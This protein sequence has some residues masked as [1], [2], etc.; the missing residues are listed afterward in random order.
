MR[1]ALHRPRHPTLIPGPHPGPPPGPGRRAAGLIL[2]LAVAL[3]AGCEGT[4]SDESVDL[5]AAPPVDARRPDARPTT[6]DAAPA[7][8]DDF[9][10]ACTAS[11]DCRSGF[12]VAG[13]GEA[14][15]CSRRC[16]DDADCPA[17]WLCR[18][19][20][21]AEADVTFIC[22]PRE[23][24]CGGADLAT[25]LAHC[26]ACDHPC[27]ALPGADPACIGGACAAGPCREGFRDLD[28]D[29]ANGCEY[30]CLLTRGG[31][32]A[33]D[34]IDNDCDGTS[35]EGFDLER[36]AAHCGACNA[37]C[38]P[39]NA[40]GACVV[41]ACEVADCA[42][43]FADE[44]GRADNGCEAARC[45]PNDTPE[46]CNGFD[47]DCDGA[48]DEGIDLAADPDHCGACDTPCRPADARGDCVSG[49]CT[50]G[51]C[52]D[53]FLDLDGAPEDGCEYACAG[54]APDDL[55]C[56]GRD[57]DCDG[58]I[59]EDVDLDA[60]PAH[61]GAC[62]VRCERPGAITTCA[63]GRCARVACEDGRLDLDGDPDNG[64]EV[65]CVPAPEQCNGRDDDCDGRVDEDFDLTTDAARC[66]ACD[67]ACAFPGAAA[68]C[69]D[70][71]CALGACLAGLADQNG[72]PADG[73]EYACVPTLGG[74]EA[75][76]AIDNDCDGDTDEDTDLAA[77][78]DHCGACNHACRLPNATPACVNGAC[79]IGA[80]LGDFQ[81]IDGR[82]ED[83]CESG[84]VPSNGGVEICDGLDNDCDDAADEGF[85][86]DADL[87]H[88][89]ACGRAC[90]PPGAE[91]VC[92]AGLCA[93]AACDAGFVDLNGD[94]RDGCEYA[95]AP[96]GDETCDGEDEDC[97]GRADEGFDLQ[98]DPSHCG[99]CDH[100]CAF[101]QGVPAC[102]GGACVLAGCAEGFVDRDGDTANGCECRVRD[103]G[104]ETCDGVDQ[105][106]DGR[107]DEGFDLQGDARHC[108]AC[109]HV[110]AA[111]NAVA[112]CRDG[113][114]AVGDCAAGFA[115]LDGDAANGCECGLQAGG[116]EAC[117]GADQ[118]C[119]GR[120]DEGFDL[121]S[122]V[123]HCGACGRVCAPAHA[124]PLC[125]AGLC[126]VDQC[127]AGFA[128]L[129]GDAANGCECG[130]QNGG[131]ERCD[132]A[133][134]DCDGRVDEG[135]DLQGD[136]RHCGACA[137]ACAPEHATPLCAAG[138]CR[139]DQCAAGFANLDGDAS[140]GCECG[141]QN[142]GVELCNGADEDCDG[143]VDEGFDLQ[144]DVR[145]CGACARAC[146]PEHATPLCAAGFAN[147]DGD[148]TNGCECGL[149]NG[150]VEL[151]N[152]ADEDCDGRSDEGFDLQGDAAHCGACGRACA[153]PHATA[154]C[155]AAACTIS[156]CDAGFVD[157]NG[158]A[159]DGCELDCA[160]AGAGS[161]ACGVAYAG[162]Y[163]LG[164][165]ASYVCHDT[166]FGDVA[167]SLNVT[168]FTFAVPGD[169]RITG[170]PA[171]MSDA[172]AP[173]DGSFGATGAIDGGPFG[174]T[175]NYTLDGSFTDGD[176]WA[177]L[178]GV[179]FSGLACDFTDCVARSFMVVGTR[180]P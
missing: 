115:N 153:L 140:N 51:A 16:G 5:D 127:A 108:G 124:T 59:D 75:C 106:C 110:C 17:D 84:C 42:P 85:D 64:C 122:D 45:Q 97:D 109:G 31:V 149:Q 32:E 46:I 167:Y 143:R 175:E 47:D 128:N 72:D 134:E 41:G 100:V 156:A 179:S 3:G 61:C 130:L 37:P 21:N 158:E 136:V 137:R 18:Q 26:G 113:Q 93:V 86:L 142:G 163:D 65:G 15:V 57:D 34:A 1:P 90:A 105:D 154:G 63:D 172:P 66:G 53:G 11:A 81:D 99:G 168:A 94:A 180:R 7:P 178:F 79:A 20:T 132:G 38:A 125:A 147:L 133:D 77:D 73:C 165:P 27:A 92:R 13:A 25:D 161:P 68:L 166:L 151:C 177:G 9:G 82:P 148:A 114:C 162:T 83:G 28:G 98:R 117:D 49:V 91:G 12:C 138:L 150:G 88:C 50:V 96:S 126:R 116:V 6:L 69:V 139:V 58:Q 141:L 112:V 14:R 103:G 123:R 78:V 70:G 135:F 95:C 170:G 40:V 23:A 30:P 169:L 121:Q 129:D 159:P 8:A 43:G 55:R 33:C 56:D 173:V 119:D 76:D 144:G 89:G 19:V 80:C 35:D 164:A 87:A 4:P 39:P 24:P 145:H 62:D 71:A 152:G 174:C 2:T 118:D 67:H 120:V 176:H 102:Q 104:V 131:V 160:G 101:D 29:L 171:P 36:D 107:V 22:V 60:D 52:R 54:V 44:D 146:A 157:A 48:I 155:S 74:R 10:E 111:E